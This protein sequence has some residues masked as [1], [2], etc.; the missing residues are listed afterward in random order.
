M[1]NTNAFFGTL[2]LAMRS[3]QAV[4]G[5]PKT[6]ALVSGGK[7]ALVLIDETASANTV[8]TVLDKCRFYGVPAVRTAEGRL[9]TAIGRPACMI[10]GVSK[11]GL[12]ELLYKKVVENKFD[13]IHL[14]LNDEQKQANL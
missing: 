7:A 2:G 4:V 10:V 1:N 14:E 11:G 12:G 13:E 6:R 8:K 9:G 3:G 5:E